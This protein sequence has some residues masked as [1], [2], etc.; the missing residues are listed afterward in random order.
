MDKSVVVSPL[1]EA[2]ATYLPKYLRAHAGSFSGDLSLPRSIAISA[3]AIMV[4]ISGFTSLMD[5]Y[6]K[7]G[8][9]GVEKLTVALNDSLGRICDKVER[10][11]GDVDAFSGDSIV[12]F[13]SVADG[14]RDA[15]CCAR[16]AIRC[17]LALIEEVDNQELA[18]GITLRMR[19]SA[20]SG[21][22]REVYL[23]GQDMQ[24]WNL[25]SGEP[26]FGLNSLLERTTS[27]QL[28]ADEATIDLLQGHATTV[29][30]SGGALITHLSNLDPQIRRPTASLAQDADPGVLASFLPRVVRESADAG[31][32]TL[33]GELR[34]ITSMFIGLTGLDVGINGDLDAIQKSLAQTQEVVGRYDGCIQSISMHDKGP[35][36]LVI[37]GLP[38][39]SHEDDASR[40]ILA[41][42]DLQVR[43][44]ALWLD[45]TC[46]IATGP[47]YCGPIGGGGRMAYSVIGD[48]VNRAARFQANGKYQVLCDRATVAAVG[49]RIRFE[50]MPAMQLKGISND[51]EIYCPRQDVDLR[52]APA[53]SFIGR[54]PETRRLAAALHDV[55][56]RR[57]PR[58]IVLRGEAGIGKSTLVEK[59][60]ELAA[61]TDFLVLHGTA[62]PYQRQLPF[63]AWRRPF[64][65]LLASTGEAGETLDQDKVTE[66]LES[67]A[68]V[69]GKAPL[70]S[71]VLPFTIPDNHFTLEIR[72]AA[73]LDNTVRALTEF[74]VEVLGKRKLLVVI[75]DAHWLDS[76]SWAL[77][78]S[79]LREKEAIAFLI[80]TRPGFQA[81]EEN[82]AA[83]D[84]MVPIQE[85][86]L[87]PFETDLTAQLIKLT[88]GVAYVPE[89]LVHFIS[90]KAGGNPFYV[91]ELTLALKAS[92][93]VAVQ[94][95][96]ASLQS[97]ASEL[98]QA[99]FPDSIEKTVL[100]R[101]DQ[102]NPRHQLILKVASVIG[103][104]FSAD[105]LRH[106]V[107][108]K[109]GKAGIQQDLR[110]LIKN[111]LLYRPSSGKSDEIR[112]NHAISRD[113]IYG[114]LLQSDRR[115]FHR[116]IA[117]DVLEG[118][119]P[120][121]FS[122]AAEHLFN[123]EEFSRAADYF[124]KSGIRVLASGT[125]RESVELL[126]KAI[127]SLE[128]SSEV[129]DKLRQAHIYRFLGEASNR[130]G[131]LPQALDYF[132]KAMSALDA[133]WPQS[134]SGLALATLRNMAQQVWRQTFGT[135]SARSVAAIAKSDEMGQIL[136]HFGHTLFFLN[137]AS[138]LILMVF[139]ST[140]QS[141]DS[142]N[143]H[144]IAPAY[145]Q[146]SNVMGIFGLH[147]FAQRYQTKFAGYRDQLSKPGRAR[148]N[149]LQSLYLSSIGEFTT[150]KAI[151]EEALEIADEI[152]DQRFKREFTSLLGVIALPM[153]DISAAA[154]RRA[155]FLELS[156]NAIDLQAK[157]WAPIQVAEIS[158]QQ[159]DSLSAIE[160]L[161]KVAPMLEHLGESESIWC[162]GNLA[163]AQWEAGNQAEALRIAE[164]T[165]QLARKTVPVSFYAL[166]GYAGAAE[167]FVRILEAGQVDDTP[168]TLPQRD[169][170]LT[171]ARQGTKALARFAKP[172][173]IAR[174]RHFIL[175]GRLEAV[176]GKNE[177]AVALL[178]RAID[179]ARKLKMPLELAQASLHL[180]AV[181]PDGKEADEL[182]ASAR[183]AFR[184]LGSVI[185]GRQVDRVEENR[186]KANAHRLTA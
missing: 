135:R 114:M 59:T 98:D 134:K 44:A 68:S 143:P 72:G 142:Q 76:A 104:E 97:T 144:L 20:V 170:Y 30:L 67:I 167:V 73:R 127:Q 140:N 1:G 95:D 110:D 119:D 153:G 139:A 87:R 78:G 185:G 90:G 130:L 31:L 123:A 64:S 102:L 2:L 46:G 166:E 81:V 101:F 66:K 41:A 79:L 155:E 179:E 19:V 11:G 39:R 172:F 184:E 57:S 14:L 138:E 61:E 125:S 47:A 32:V 150:C 49:N 159:G 93:A 50:R 96:T 149:Q 178:R 18:E 164:S 99:G 171:S 152:G 151:L 121:G 180:G 156:A 106:V 181:L 176:S 173:L 88:L 52:Q 29:A 118:E 21:D 28:A 27:G 15:R 126:E 108:E 112:F 137:R 6:A 160:T 186:A 111:R 17:A 69:A 128:R 55:G 38:H 84:A 103:T 117:E 82:L 175:A 158:L 100:A 7:S 75:D 105:T 162:N 145:L 165:C 33:T 16:D 109:I 74:M 85:L 129:P 94:G 4:D 9:R 43:L 35:M 113:V 25:I 131:M 8:A 26:L 163:L 132:R 58:A 133:D 42:R 147:S 37:F 91:N 86:S 71:A 45:S 10:F 22:F 13:W 48:A 136:E 169:G 36:I 40:S 65:R 124:E 120:S 141:E 51:V 54:E 53:S 62:D 182:I 34:T 83:L 24:R 107:P 157:A 161:G 177:R 122:V 77:I 168:L 148:C 89:E 116:S 56:S 63:H 80:A 115:A 3:T 5:H 174:P 146:M 60:K 23:G 92:G 12:A 183:T 154:A 70:F